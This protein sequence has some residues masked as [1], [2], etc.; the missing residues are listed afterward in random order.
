MPRVNCTGPS[1]AAALQLAA[2]LLDGFPNLP[3]HRGD[4]AS[5]QV[6]YLLRRASVCEAVWEHWNDN[7]CDEAVASCDLF[8]YFAG[9]FCRHGV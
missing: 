1:T 5:L 6:Q 2:L 4:C 8:T 3:V 7:V 9:E